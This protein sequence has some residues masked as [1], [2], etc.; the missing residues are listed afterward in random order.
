VCTLL[1]LY[2]VCVSGIADCAFV[3]CLVQFNAGSS[4]IMV[5]L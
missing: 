2:I 3:L 5:V 4:V 1:L